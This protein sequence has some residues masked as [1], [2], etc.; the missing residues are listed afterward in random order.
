MSTSNS[1]TTSTASSGE[2]DLVHY[3]KVLKQFLD[4]S[5]DPTK[6]KSNSS[7]AQRAREKLLKLSYTQFKELSTDVYD[8]LRRRIDESRGEPDYLLPKKTFH[9]KRNQARQKLASLPQSRF[10]DLVSDISFE[11]ERRELHVSKTNRKDSTVSV[12]T[13][14]SSIL[15]TSTSDKSNGYHSR[16]P[17]RITQESH[18][19]HNAATTDGEEGTLTVPANVFDARN[20]PTHLN[21]TEGTNRELVNGGSTSHQFPETNNTEAAPAGH[22]I[23]IQQSTVVP[24]KANLD[25]SSSDDEETTETFNQTPQ[26]SQAKELREDEDIPRKLELLF[27]LEKTHADDQAQQLESLVG[28]LQQQLK[29]AR[30]ESNKLQEKIDSLETELKFSVN[31]SKSLEGKV[32]R[33]L[34]EKDTWISKENES[35]ARE[36]EFESSLEQLKTQNSALKQENLTLKEQVSVTSSS[37]GTFSTNVPAPLPVQK[38]IETLLN[39]LE[40]LDISKQI[41]TPTPMIVDLRDQIKLWQSKYEDLRADGIAKSIKRTSLSTADL[42]KFISPQGMISIRLVSDVYAKFESFLTYLSQDHY[43]ADILFEKISKI[44][45]MVNE[46]ASQGENQQLNSNENSVLLRESISHVLTASRYHAVYKNLLPRFVIE[47]CVGEVCFIMCDLI[48]TCKLNENSTNV[49]MIG[50]SQIETKG[51]VN[52]VTEEFGVR[53][54]RMANKLKSSQSHQQY[55]N[56]SPLSSSSPKPCVFTKVSAWTSSTHHTTPTR[57]IGSRNAEEQSQQRERAQ[58]RPRELPTPSPQKDSPTKIEETPSKPQRVPNEEQTQV[59]HPPPEKAKSSYNEADT[60]PFIERKLSNDQSFTTHGSSITE[61]ETKTPRKSS[62]ERTSDTHNSP[63]SSR[64]INEIASKFESR[65]PSPKVLKSRISPTSKGIFEIAKKYGSPREDNSGGEMNGNKPIKTSPVVTKG[66]GILD[67]VRQFEGSPDLNSRKTSLVSPNVSPIRLRV[68]SPVTHRYYQEGSPVDHQKDQRTSGSPF[69]HRQEQHVDNVSTLN[70]QEQV[71]YVASDAHHEHNEDSAESCVSVEQ[72]TPLHHHKDQQEQNSSVDNKDVEQPVRMDPIMDHD[73]QDHAVWSE[74]GKLK[75]HDNKDEEVNEDQYHESP[76]VERIRR[77]SLVS[78]Q[79]MDH[80]SQERASIDS[81]QKVEQISNQQRSLSPVEQIRK[82]IS[83]DPEAQKRLSDPFHVSGKE[84]KTNSGFRTLREKLE[85]AKHSDTTSF[86]SEDT[87]EEDHHRVVS[88]DQR[89]SNSTAETTPSNED[90]VPNLFKDNDSTITPNTPL[91]QPSIPTVSQETIHENIKPHVTIQEPAHYRNRHSFESEAD[92]EA[93]EEE[94]ED[95]DEE[96][97]KAAQARQ[98]QEYRKSMA[99]ATFNVDLFDIDDP[100]NTLTQVLLYLEHQTVE[101]INTIQSLLSAIKRPNATRGELR[102][103][104]KAITIVISQM[105][106][107]TNTSMNQTRNAQLKEHGSWVVRSLEDC[108]HRMDNLCKPTTDVLD[109]SFADKNFK[110]RLAGISF[111]IAK[112]TKELV[113][114]VE[115]A[116]LKEDIEHLSARINRNEDDDLT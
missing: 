73:N 102:E 19:Q 70:Q 80:P 8:E 63:S 59:Q 69:N 93:E 101:V 91:Q 9:P 54:L 114:T 96:D 48:S 24:S 56:Q 72:T 113:K 25:W 83:G 35:A 38:N 4:I 46:V 74:D 61:A 13:N 34:K 42:N 103:K 60:S 115:E 65:S 45:V 92:S 84:V 10:K 7:R 52:T 71:Q 37:P 30:Y 99:A 106:E 90:P 100:D 57:Q 105:T 15:T 6:S 81:Q 32:E 33:L 36:K 2:R 98:R 77:V 5:D 82:Q 75:L 86:D 85:E 17:S 107:A 95:D 12:F 28:E 58:T 50:P 18:H 31:Q 87:E 110:Q 39:K 104:S 76:V 49:K 94:E 1:T 111:D 21:D 68:T 53:P 3:Y 108:Y 20:E 55:Q 40:Q 64:G 22:S 116:S 66:K 41:S 11:I 62:S 44:S 109:S 14:T 29:E 67:K 51:N 97:R 26:Q 79:E 112:C 23:G 88:D 43:D 89:L 27:P 16:Q 78:S 47:R